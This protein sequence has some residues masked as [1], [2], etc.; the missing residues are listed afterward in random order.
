MQPSKILVV[1]RRDLLETRVDLME[2]VTPKHTY[3]VNDDTYDSVKEP[4][5]IL[6]GLLGQRYVTC[7]HG[8]NA[9][10]TVVPSNADAVLPVE[11]QATYAFLTLLRCCVY[12][13]KN[14][15]LQ[16]QSKRFTTASRTVKEYLY[17]FAVGRMNSMYKFQ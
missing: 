4:A 1:Y 3:L 6:L 7:P 11:A 2:Y 12:L 9:E 14:F 16:S 10:C 5:V 8:L 17:L 15:Y 13:L